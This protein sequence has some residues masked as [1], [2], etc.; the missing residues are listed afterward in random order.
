MATTV[1]APRQRSNRPILL[2]ALVF[3]LITAGLAYLAVTQAT[4]DESAGSSSS[5]SS[6]QLASETVVVAAVDIPARSVIT[7]DMLEARSVPVDALQPG[8]FTATEDVV[9]S[10]AVYPTPAGHQVLA[11][12]VSEFGAEAALSYII[13]E[14][15]R[16]IA[17]N[18]T[19]VKAVG[20]YILPGDFVDIIGLFAW[21]ANDQIVVTSTLA[22]D[23]EVLAV[24]RVTELL[25]LEEGVDGGP[26]LANSERKDGIPLV[27]EENPDAL[28][29]I[30]AVT[31]QE[32]QRVF[33]ADASNDAEFRF[34][35]RRTGEHETSFLPA[36]IPIFGH[37]GDTL[38][39]S[40]YGEPPV[41]LAALNEADLCAL[42]QN[43]IAAA[44][45]AEAAGS[46]Q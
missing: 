45:E 29:L 34:V 41:E 43:A 2:L 10:V 36:F 38:D 14:G 35:L 24:E 28:Y 15:H 1:A 37:C 20:G 17:V 9:G 16:A 11:A 13:P 40:L 31:P 19:A 8:S 46:G 18:A 5:S 44:A 22:Q 42:Q 4:Q 6:A 12:N 26:P 39:S 25:E 33:A 23:S 27:G 21:T 3:G 30:V 32:A 7:L